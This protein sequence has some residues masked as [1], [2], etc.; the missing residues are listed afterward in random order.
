MI[1]RVHLVLYVSEISEAGNSL[2]VLSTSPI[3]FDAFER[4]EVSEIVLSRA[5]STRPAG[6]GVILKYPRGILPVGNT[7]E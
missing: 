3:C 2:E 1:G 4:V 5:D 7:N 6:R